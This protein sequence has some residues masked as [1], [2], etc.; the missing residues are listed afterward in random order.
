M[1]KTGKYPSYFAKVHCN[2][3]VIVTPMRLLKLL[4]R[5]MDLAREKDLKCSFSSVTFE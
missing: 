5:F 3:K 4:K 2:R 1:E